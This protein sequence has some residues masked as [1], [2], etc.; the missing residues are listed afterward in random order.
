VTNAT[1]ETEC[2]LGIDI[3]AQSVRDY[4]RGFL[5][6]IL[7]LSV[8]TGVI[9]LVLSIWYSRRISKPLLSLAENLG[10][11]Q[12]LEL[13][14]PVKVNSFV[15]EV[16]VMR[17]AVERMKNS[18]KSFRK[19][20]PADLVADLMALGQEARLSAEK[21]EVTVFF[22][23]IADFTTISEKTPPEQLVDHLS[24]YFDAM[25]RSIIEN[26]GT[27]DKYIGDAIMAFWSAPRTLTD[28]AVKACQ[29]ALKCRDHSRRIGAEQQK[30]G[31][32]AMY[33]RIGLN[34][35]TVIIG[36]IGYDARLNYTAK[37]TEAGLISSSSC[38]KIAVRSFHAEKP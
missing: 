33:T 28:H 2:G 18:L 14:H 9:V 25:T 12:R 30:S 23:D 10:R 21:R 26:Q 38:H 34:T 11:V 16:V 27:V 3:S 20:V 1:G 17:E 36:N 37:P 7:N 35:G 22:S 5:A 8:I 15:R 29:A 6:T 24:V 4:E 32:A 13:D 19:Y 31:K